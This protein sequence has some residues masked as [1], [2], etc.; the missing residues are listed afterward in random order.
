MKCAILTLLVGIV[1]ASSFN[2]LPK[3][4]PL[5]LVDGDALKEWREFTV[6]HNKSYG[7]P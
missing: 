4:V 1:G 6:T 3:G 7:S 5:P 2:L